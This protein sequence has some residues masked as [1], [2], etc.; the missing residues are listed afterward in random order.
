M[1]PERDLNIVPHTVVMG[2]YIKTLEG[3]HNPLSGGDLEV[4]GLT[5]IHAVVT[6]IVDN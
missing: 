5:I 6:L 3:E 2:L 4:P 1:R